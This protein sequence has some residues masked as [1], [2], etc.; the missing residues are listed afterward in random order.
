MSVAQEPAEWLWAA[1]GTRQ[2][3]SKTVGKYPVGFL[4]MNEGHL[5]RTL[6]TAWHTGSDH[7][8][9]CYSFFPNFQS[10]CRPYP[11][12]FP[13]TLLPR[14]GS[15]TETQTSHKVFSAGEQT[16]P[17]CSIAHGKPTQSTPLPN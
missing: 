15:H 12:G 9:I 16:R 2:G 5:R 14:E 1:S 11:S 13:D 4:R 8:P 3:F 10:Y 6:P 7:K 17:L